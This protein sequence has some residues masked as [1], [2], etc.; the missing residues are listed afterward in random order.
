ML[1]NLGDKLKAQRWLGVLIL[2]ILAVIFAMWGAYGIVD[3][4]FGTPSYALRVNGEEVP[5]NTV[6]QAWQQRQSQLQQQVNG[7]IPLE[8][9]TALQKQVMEEYIGSTLL[10][11]RASARGLR[12]DNA[13]VLAA[14]QAESAFQVDGKFN[15]A[16]ARAM[17]LQAG[18]TPAAYE[19]DLRNSL[20]VGQL[21]QGL[22]ATDFL[23]GSELTRIFALEN[24]QRE[25]RYAMLA[26]E[27]YA[28]TANVDDGRMQSWYQEHLDNYQTPESASLQ[29]AELRL[30]ALTTEVAVDPAELS[31]W[32][33]TN[34][35]RYAEPEKRHA[36]H[37]LIQLDAGANAAT[38]A[39]ALK[40][41]QD[42]AVQARAGKDF[43][44][45]A[46]QYS[47]DA[48]SKAQGGDLG[49]MQAGSSLDAAFS[50]ALYS[51]QTGQ[52][53]DP[54]KSA[55]GYHI[56]RLEE[57]QAAKGRTLADARAEIEA[58]YRRERASELF[59]DRQEQLQQKLESASS[60][61]PALAKEFGL[62]AGEI[63][64]Y[65]HAGAAPL[66]FNADLDRLVFSEEIR[67][68]GRIG[69]PVALS[70]DR[71]VIVKVLAYHAPQPRPL[72]QVRADVIAA[73]R[74]DEGGK[75]AR[76]AAE[77]AVKQLNEGA[78]LETVA[79]SLGVTLTP[80]AL[81]GRGDP[82]LPVEVRDAAFATVLPAGKPGFRALPLEAGGAALIAVLAVKPG[83]SGVNPT[84]DQQLA[85]QMAKRQREAES[86]AYLLEMR[87]KA[88]VR[89]NDAVFN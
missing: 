58:D 82:Q 80:A 2:G 74:K 10:R 5:A 52:I 85:G 57:I 83:A 53:S 87:R 77:A 9:R 1:Q 43:A 81:V 48:G 17:L 29:Y 55:F 64:E 31:A 71:L 23:T 65:T 16:A 68:G 30:D 59:G 27:R 78:A 37:I 86:A 7:E 35:A 39:A 89:E 20:Q 54:V 72:E 46:K 42:I 22:Q 40:K 61:L 11:Q 6:Q 79:K 12:V 50:A 44:A 47:D 70:E 3:I 4:S 13:A 84:N 56:I 73:I 24:E 25:L 69:G 49:W 38:A 26:P 51:M 62:Q 67:G 34:K 60:D 75:A 32:Y 15:E 19:A 18:L 63:A 28:A 21:T 88:K 14:Y 45:L 41:A 76:A 66:G 33:E 36:R 8:Q